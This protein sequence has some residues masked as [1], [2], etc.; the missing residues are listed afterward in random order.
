MK[1]YQGAITSALIALDYE[2]LDPKL[3]NEA[4]LTIA[5]CNLMQNNAAEAEAYFEKVILGGIPSMAAEASYLRARQ[6]FLNDQLD[7]AE[8]SVFNMVGKYKSEA[9]WIAKALILLS[10]VY[11]TRG[12][13]FQATATLQSIL[14]NYPT[15]DEVKAQAKEKLKNI[16]GM[17][18]QQQEVDSVDF[19]IYLSDPEPTPNNN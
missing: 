12:D 8:A 3:Y 4:N 7:S 6:F 17:Q 5:K 9:I 16:Q 1:N 18:S 19:E 15:E 13:V 10:D 11:I 14:D 2:K